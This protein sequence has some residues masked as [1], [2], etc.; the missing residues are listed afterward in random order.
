MSITTTPVEIITDV[1]TALAKAIDIASITSW[2]V[3]VVGSFFT[4]AAAQSYFQS[5]PMSLFA[6]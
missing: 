1:E 3:L 2:G 5:R 6:K 4:V